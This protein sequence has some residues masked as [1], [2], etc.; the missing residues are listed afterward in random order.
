MFASSA[1]RRFS[2]NT[3]GV[4]DHVI[5]SHGEQNFMVISF[6]F[7]ILNTVKLYVAFSLFIS[8]VDKIRNTLN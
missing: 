8:S 1:R 2:A 7:R 6:E 4:S 3:F 5:S